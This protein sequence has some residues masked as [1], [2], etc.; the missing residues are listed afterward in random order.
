VTSLAL[1]TVQFGLEYG[2]T[3]AGGKVPR[4][5]A[6]R[7]LDAFARDGGRWLDTAPTYGDSESLLG[8]NG[9]AFSIVDKTIHVDLAM[10]FDDGIRALED[11]LRK[12]LAHLNRTRID[13]LLCHQAWLL[14]PPWRDV[15]L[16]WLTSRKAAGQIGKIGVSI[17]QPADLDNVVWRW[18]DWIQ[19][20][21]NALD[22]R[23]LRSGWVARL[24]S[25]GVVTQARS[26][27]LQGVLL[28]PRNARI[29]IP[30]KAEVAIAA[31]HRVA[32]RLMLTPE[33]LAL[34][35]GCY[36]GVNQVVVGV[37]SLPEYEALRQ[38]WREAQRL[39]N[40][41]VDWA[42]LSLDDHPW[43]N[44]SNWKELA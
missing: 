3:H 23:M 33:A 39:A 41:D 40:D 1:G 2:A 14:Q 16:D 17:Y 18:L 13:V 30:S 24:H 12:S 43:L 34:A 35:F 15:V 32:E 21:L 6:K 22:Q 44:P 9:F 25:A 37:H 19:F 7:I 36:A 38:A 42:R 28:A 29:E 5:E 27:Y 20:P 4:E 31:F 10:D 8:R 26:L 11:G